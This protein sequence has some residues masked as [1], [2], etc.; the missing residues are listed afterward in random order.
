MARHFNVES[1]INEGEIFV[2]DQY[3]RIVEANREGRLY[4]GMT[5]WEIKEKKPHAS[6]IVEELYAAPIRDESG[7]YRGKLLQRKGDADTREDVTLYKDGAVIGRSKVLKK[8]SPEEERELR[9]VEFMLSYFD[10]EDWR[11]L[12][13]VCDKTL[14]IKYDGIAPKL[15]KVISLVMQRSSNWYYLESLSR[16]AMNQA[17]R[18]ESPYFFT[19]AKELLIMTN[20]GTQSD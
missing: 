3:E 15:G 13:R 12:A 9:F 18:I 11:G 7:N 17:A 14:E 6:N 1:K 5:E 8:D 4:L 10:R 16:R 20:R 19:L 2:A